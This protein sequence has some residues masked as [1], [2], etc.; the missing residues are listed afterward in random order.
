MAAQSFFT[1]IRA[2]ILLFSRWSMDDETYSNYRRNGEAEA[3]GR[4]AGL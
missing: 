1:Q 2:K 4:R 3:D